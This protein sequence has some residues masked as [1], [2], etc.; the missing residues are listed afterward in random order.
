MALYIHSV[1]KSGKGKITEI[2]I[3]QIQEN[4]TLIYVLENSNIGINVYKIAQND[5]I[6][7][8]KRDLLAA[9]PGIKLENL[10]SNPAQ[11]LGKYINSSELEE[12]L[13]QYQKKLTA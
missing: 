10:F 6:N 3:G 1:T 2:A 8:K 11:H 7:F 12:L 5:P 4:K 13:A 9:V